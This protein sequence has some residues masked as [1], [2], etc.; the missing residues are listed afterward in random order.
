MANKISDPYKTV[1][2]SGTQSVY[3]NLQ[4]FGLLETEKDM[5]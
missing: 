3:F 5:N 1:A 2:K 4:V